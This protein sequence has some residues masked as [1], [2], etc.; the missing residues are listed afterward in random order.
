MNIIVWSDIKYMYNVLAE[1][2]PLNLE[3]PP[4]PVSRG[5]LRLPGGAKT[6][7]GM[8]NDALGHA[9]PGCLGSALKF[10]I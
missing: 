6:V 10:V 8:A 3:G 4:G 9:N 7:R 1:A 5:A 2:I